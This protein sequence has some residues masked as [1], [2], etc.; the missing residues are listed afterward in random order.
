VARYAPAALVAALL[1]ATGLAFAYTEQLKLTRSPVFGTRV[2][3]VIGPTCA[4]PT[5]R[6]RISF[7]LR[8]RDRLTL[9]IVRSGDVVRTLVSGRRVPKGRFTTFWNGKDDA[10]RVVEEGTYRPEVKL[11]GERRTIVLPNRIR[12]DTTPP[13]VRLVGAQPRVFSPDGDGRRDRVVVRYRADGPARVSLYADEVRVGRKRGQQ[14]EGRIDWNG[15]MDGAPPVAGRYALDVRAV[16]VAGNESKP[17]RAVDVLI[18]FVAL[19]RDRIETRPGARFSVLVLSDARRVEWRLGARRG[20][21]R[22]GTL[23]LRAPLQPGRFTLLVSA[24]GFG[25]RAAVFVRRPPGP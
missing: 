3:K 7:R 21:A 17:S 23:R 6:A 25:A 12:V 4:C 19:G 22:P 13:V 18:R 16:D 11:A 24:N 8:E 5:A 15:R 9:A 14:T 2:D 10:G 20:T 1:L